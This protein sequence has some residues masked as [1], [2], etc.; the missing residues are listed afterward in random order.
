M[1][2]V[3]IAFCLSQ[4][5]MFSGLNL[6]F[7]SISRLRLEVEK[8]QGNRAAATVL[9]LRS[10]SNFL[11][12]TILWGN[13]GINVLLTLLSNQVLLGVGAFM[14][15]T[16]FITLFGEIVP[17][18]YFS[19][20]A[21]RLAGLL[22]PVLKIYQ[23][24]LYPVAKP[25][26]I[27]LDRWLGIEDVQLYK[28]KQFKEMIAL[29]VSDETSDIDAV[30]GTGA[31]NFLKLDDLAVAEEGE[32][33]DPGSIIMLPSSNGEVVFPEF[34]CNMDDAFLQKIQ[35][36]K[37]KWV[38]FTDE[39][40]IPHLALDADDFLRE[41]LFTKSAL[42]PHHFCH[43]PIVVKDPKTPLDQ[44]ISR[45]NVYPERTEDDVIDEDIILLWGEQKKVI[46]GADIL[47]RL[48]RG[49]ASMQDMRRSSSM[50]SKRV[51]D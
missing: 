11:L 28:E 5:A 40:N 1:I 41:V 23:I 45:L 8:R 19:R 4:S 31:L 47:G 18:A 37:K 32:R 33:L 30:E 46:T 2:W 48:L 26:A 49:I 38:I 14:F 21:L 16:V 29:H 24:V 42:D 43:R 9:N 7:F 17:Q 3:G 6:A 27:L 22:S 36:S 12:T 10:D 15:S 34:T 13:V 44:V 51:V 39:R 50:P 35:Q 20:N 25:A